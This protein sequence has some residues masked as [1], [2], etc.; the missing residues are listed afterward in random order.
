MK[1]KHTLVRSWVGDSGKQGRKG[2]GGLKLIT[3]RRKPGLN[4]RGVE[5]ETGVERKGKGEGSRE[6]QHRLSWQSVR[7]ESRKSSKPSKIK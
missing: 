2:K 5:G 6:D 7:T 3:E 4:L 1:P